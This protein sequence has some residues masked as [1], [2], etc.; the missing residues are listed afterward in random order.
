M[1]DKRQLARIHIL[2]KK[3][4]LSDD[5]YR[6]MLGSFGAGVNEQG[7]PSSKYLSDEQA[8]ALIGLLEEQSRGLTGYDIP[9]WGKEKYE[10]LRGRPGGFA[11]PQQ[12]RKIEA[13]WRDKARNPGDGALL[14]FVERQ[15]GIKRLEWLKSEHAKAVLTALK[16]M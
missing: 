10:Y 3:A 14:R 4:G 2:K 15:T 8:E 16:H 6:A 13:I 9:G 1:P 12:L 11:Q 7:E 5:E